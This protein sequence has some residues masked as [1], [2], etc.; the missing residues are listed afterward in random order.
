MRASRWATT[1]I[2][3]SSPSELISCIELSR[4]TVS[5]KTACGKSTVS[6]TGKI[7]SATAG[8]SAFGAVELFVVLVSLAMGMIAFEQ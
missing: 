5:G 6:R 8:S 7:G 1:M 3:F 2:C 4:P